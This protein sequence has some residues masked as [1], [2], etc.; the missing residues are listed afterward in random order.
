MA[1][2]LRKRAQVEKAFEN[3]LKEKKLRLFI[4]AGS[5][6]EDYWE[7]YAIC[8]REINF[9]TIREEAERI[10]RAK[11]IDPTFGFA[12]KD[13]AEEALHKLACHILWS[14]ERYYHGW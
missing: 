7:I 6:Y 9:P 5:M 2:E 1:E 13:P 10:A 8:P 4:I 11:N 3:F 14:K 12:M